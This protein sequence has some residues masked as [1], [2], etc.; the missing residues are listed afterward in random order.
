VFAAQIAQNRW[1]RR[2]LAFF[3]A[4]CLLSTLLSLTAV[5]AIGSVLSGFLP[6]GAVTIL[7]LLV[8]TVLIFYGLRLL[9][10]KE[11]AAQA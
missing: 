6:E 5:A 2:Q 1:N 7:N 4:G 9:L 8:G 11:P 10:K 3:A